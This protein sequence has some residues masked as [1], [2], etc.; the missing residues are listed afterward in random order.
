[1][2]FLPFRFA[3]RS[4]SLLGTFKRVS[5]LPIIICLLALDFPLSLPESAAPFMPAAYEKS[6]RPGFF[7]DV[8][9]EVKLELVLVSFGPVD[10]KRM[11]VSS[12]LYGRCRWKD[13][14]LTGENIVWSL[15][16]RKILKL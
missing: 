7:Q 14:R 11:T 5:F 2:S 1:M 10:N 3:E 9:T 4:F 15:M 16:T 12:E 6:I 8:P 13:E